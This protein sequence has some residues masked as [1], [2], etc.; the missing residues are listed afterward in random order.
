MQQCSADLGV[1]LETVAEQRLNQLPLQL[2]LQP[3]Q[4]Q[5][6]QEPDVILEKHTLIKAYITVDENFV[7]WLIGKQFASVTFQ[8]QPDGIKLDELVYNVNAFNKWSLLIKRDC[9]TLLAG[10]K[11]AWNAYDQKP[12]T[13][14]IGKVPIDGGPVGEFERYSGYLARYKN[15]SKLFTQSEWAE[16][17]DKLDGTVLLSNS[18]TSCV[19]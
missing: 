16:E 13:V 7:A 17:M 12:K 1:P 19:Y 11:E 6:V 8:S 9:K 10:L 15:K 18:K 14:L 5:T 4:L 3:L 2:P